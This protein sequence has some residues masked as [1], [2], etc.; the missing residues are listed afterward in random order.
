MADD[1]V[2][3]FDLCRRHFPLLRRRAH[4]HGAGAG[5]GLA[6]LLEGVGHGVAAT[7]ALQVAERQV[8]VALGVSRCAFDLHLAPVGVQ[9]LGHQGGEAGVAALAHLHMLGDH[10]D[11]AIGGDSNEGV[12]FEIAGR[13]GVAQ[14]TQQRR[15]VDAQGQAA[16]PAQEPAAADVEDAA[17]LGR[18]LVDSGFE[19]GIGPQARVWAAS[20]MAARIRA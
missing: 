19:H 4:Q 9:F 5:A 8:G 6:H 11:G 2:V 3:H 18:L 10:G 20:W 12:R 13:P 16:G 17:G 1:A 7:G 14:V 15:K